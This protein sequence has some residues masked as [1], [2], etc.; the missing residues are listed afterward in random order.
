M[1][2]VA[3]HEDQEDDRPLQATSTEGHSSVES[4][5]SRVSCGMQEK[6][7]GAALL[8]PGLPD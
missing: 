4:Q 8:T 5:D 6:G 2:N 3:T 7:K 1:G